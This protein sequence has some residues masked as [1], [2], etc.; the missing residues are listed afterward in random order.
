M[1]E[2][3]D[4]QRVVGRCISDNGNPNRFALSRGIQTVNTG[5]IIKPK[6]PESNR[7]KAQGLIHS[8]L[9]DVG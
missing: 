1:S 6:T 9:R 2:A 7:A 4:R 5:R 8:K 3:R